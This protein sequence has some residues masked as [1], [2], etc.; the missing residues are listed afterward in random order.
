MIVDLHPLSLA[1]LLETD[2]ETDLQ[3]DR[4]INDPLDEVEQ[5]LVQE[6]ILFER[7]ADSEIQFSLSGAW[8]DY[9]MWFRWLAHPNALQVSLGI[10][11]KVP[12]QQKNEVTDLIVQINERLL[13]GHFDMWSADRTL[14][15]RHTQLIEPGE[16]IHEQMAKKLSDA[17]F[18]AAEVLTPALGFLL[19]SDKSAS[20]AV[21]AAMFETIGEA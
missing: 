7:I 15:Y 11:T 1:N 4:N 6:Q 18:E 5:F 16:I 12:K 10:E 17:A 13:L 3:P 19:W 21:E 20:E 14:V 2:L 9:P 8:C